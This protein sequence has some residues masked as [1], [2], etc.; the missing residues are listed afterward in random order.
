LSLI[1]RVP[2]AQPAKAQDVKVLRNATPP[3]ACTNGTL[4]HRLAFC[5]SQGPSVTTVIDSLVPW[6]ELMVKDLQFSFN[7]HDQ[8]FLFYVSGDTNRNV[9]SSQWTTMVHPIAS[10]QTGLR[11]AT[12]ALGVPPHVAGQRR[13]RQVFSWE[14][15]S[16]AEIVEVTS[17]PPSDRTTL[18][19]IA[20]VSQGVVCDCVAFERCGARGTPERR[21]GQTLAEPNPT[22]VATPLAD[23]SPVFL[24][25]SAID[26]TFGSLHS[27]RTIFRTVEER[28]LTSAPLMPT[29]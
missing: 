22:R 15:A 20:L 25:G 29:D 27:T 9:S 24:Y 1:R 10:T 18:T 13:V 8:P 12:D 19:N 5:V 6:I 7:E 17:I 21:C 23:V 14:D 26:E 4:V 11:R 28:C 16:C 3:D 2:R